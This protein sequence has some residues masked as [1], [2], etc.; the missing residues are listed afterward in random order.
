MGRGKEEEGSGGGGKV[1]HRQNLIFSFNLMEV[2]INAL[3][4][5]QN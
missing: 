5:E 4:D 2:T 1:G 3:D